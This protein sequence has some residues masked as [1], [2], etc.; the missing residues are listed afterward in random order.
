M[1]PLKVAGFVPPAVALALAVAL[2]PLVRALA[3]TARF[4]REAQDRSLA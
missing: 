1:F 4:C 3:A 2:T